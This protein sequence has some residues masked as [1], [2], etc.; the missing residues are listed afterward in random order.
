MEFLKLNYTT[1]SGMK[2]EKC[3]VIGPG[4]GFSKSCKERQEEKLG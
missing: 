3:G 2:W 1:L 4:K